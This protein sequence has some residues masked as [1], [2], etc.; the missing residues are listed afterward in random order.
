MSYIK[1]VNARFRYTQNTPMRHVALEYSRI[2][3]GIAFDWKQNGLRGFFD[4]VVVYAQQL[5][6]DLGR[7]LGGLPARTPAHRP[8]EK[9][10]LG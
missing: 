6:L 5:G 9:A 7:L 10:G 8:F 4:R 2:N 1:R 3:H